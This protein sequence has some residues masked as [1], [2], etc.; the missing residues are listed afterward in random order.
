MLSESRFAAARVALA[1]GLCRLV[2]L[3]LLAAVNAAYLIGS[4][5]Q[6]VDQLVKAIQRSKS[7]VIASQSATQVTLVSPRTTNW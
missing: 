6:P 7:W 3:G 2:A 1:C 4:C 5:T